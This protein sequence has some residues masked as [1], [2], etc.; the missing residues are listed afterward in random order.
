[1][2]FISSRA[3]RYLLEPIHKELG[4]DPRYLIVLGDRRE[5][6]A[7]ALDAFDKNLPIVHIQGGERTPYSK[8]DV[9]RDCITRMASLHFPPTHDAAARIREISPKARIVMCGAVG[10]QLAKELLLISK[11]S[12]QEQGFK[13]GSRTWL[14]TFHPQPGED[15]QE[16]IDALKRGT[17]NSKATKRIQVEL[18]DYSFADTQT[19]K[20]ITGLSGKRY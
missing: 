4:N 1:M 3:D 8:N 2:I 16:L 11:D 5:T 17:S 10:A 9:H 20:S 7:A 19:R 6:L 14:V 12:L 15:V 18:L 13:F